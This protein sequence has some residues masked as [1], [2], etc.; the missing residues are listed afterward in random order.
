M[1][2]LTVFLNSI[3]GYLARNH[4]VQSPFKFFLDNKLINI[5]ITFKE[6][7]RNSNIIVSHY[8]GYI[9]IRR[10]QH[11]SSTYYRCHYLITEIISHIS[12]SNS[13][14]SHYGAYI[15]I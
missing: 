1:T 12:N 2:E 15:S 13:I 5:R 11:M 4:Q 14:V 7:N 9:S 8:G 10:K 6:I 3:N